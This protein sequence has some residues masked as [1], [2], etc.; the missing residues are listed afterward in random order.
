MARFEIPALETYLDEHYKLILSVEFFRLF[1][2]NDLQI[3]TK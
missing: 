3:V 1:L 2:R